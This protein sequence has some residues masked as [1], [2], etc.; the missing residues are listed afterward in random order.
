MRC[1]Y[2]I[3]PSSMAFFSRVEVLNNKHRPNKRA[4][5]SVGNRDSIS[6]LS[7]AGDARISSYFDLLV[8][9]KLHNFHDKNSRVTGVDC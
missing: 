7:R 3:Y 9:V 2:Y 4:C 5:P 6:K 1:I 8:K